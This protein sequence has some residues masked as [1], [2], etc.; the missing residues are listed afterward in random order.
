VKIEEVNTIADGL[1]ASEADPVVF[2]IVER[3]VDDIV[4][5]TDDEVL[6]GV[7][8]LLERARLVAEPAGAATTAALLTDKVKLPEGMRTVVLISGGNYDVER[9]LE[10]K[11]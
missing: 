9:R 7:R 10:L 4:L 6:F 5:L 2:D 11:Y 1:T 8:F 3:L